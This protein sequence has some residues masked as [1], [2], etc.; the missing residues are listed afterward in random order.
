MATGISYTKS[1]VDGRVRLHLK[2]GLSEEAI[3]E[4]YKGK[5]DVLWLY[6]GNFADLGLT[7]IQSLDCKHL[8]FQSSE[9]QDVSWLSLL[10]H[11][12]TLSLRGKIKGRID[13]SGLR[14]LRE[15]SVEWGS[16]TK[17]ILEAGLPLESLDLKRF[18]GSLENVAEVTSLSLRILGVSGS[19]ES[20]EGVER[21]Q[22]LEKLSLFRM[23]KLTDISKISECRQLREL[24]IEACNSI[25]DLDPISCVDSL[26]RMFFENKLLPSLDIIPK[27]NV[28]Y[29][30]LGDST[31]IEDM[32]VEKALDF[33]DLKGISYPFRKGY[34]YSAEEL[35]K[36]INKD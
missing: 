30:R 23:T 19:I 33:K 29:I 21:F 22:N 2:E 1:P 24:H 28:N 9:S 15:C 34:K 11:L 3:T 12:A 5:Y 7:P 8:V 13:F 31:V 32:D 18:S 27:K 26:E 17:S 10:G 20:L 4:I 6:Y 25:Q 16:A 36:L 14:N 35:N